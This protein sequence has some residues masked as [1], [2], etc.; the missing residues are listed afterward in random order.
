MS[1]RHI[2]FTK[3]NYTEEDIANFLNYD[4]NFMTFAKETGEKEETPHLQGY[5][6]PNDKVNINKFKKEFKCWAATAK[7][8]SQACIDY[9]NKGEQ[10]K[11]EWEAQKTMGPNYGLN[12]DVY[13]TGEPR[14]QGE[15]V[16]L[17]ILGKRIREGE[18]TPIDVLIENPMM[19]HQYGRT[20]EKIVDVMNRKKY[21]THTTKGLWL[22]GGTGAGKSHKAF[23]DFNPETTYVWPNDKRWWDGYTSQHETVVMNDFRGEIP[24][25]TLLQLLDKWPMTVP[26]RNK[27]PMPFTA[28]RIIITSSLQPHQV[29]KQREDEDKIAQ[30]LRRIEVCEITAEPSENYEI[31]GDNLLTL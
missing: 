19:Y 16:D 23:E 1:V 26:R 22:W 18:T 14:F 8:S 13:S 11:S 30:L 27:E 5:M 3:N 20:L 25:N 10:K 9:V 7:G 28:K 31:F 2:V 24:Y 6:Q 15:R 21:R 4:C 29:Y 12:K 17:K